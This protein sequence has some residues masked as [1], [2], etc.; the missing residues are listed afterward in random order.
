[1][2]N[3]GLEKR[4]FFVAESGCTTFYGRSQIMFIRQVFR[5]IISLI[6]LLSSCSSEQTDSE[7]TQ[8]G[9]S[10][11]VEVPDDLYQEG[12]IVETDEYKP[13]TKKLTVYGMILVG[14]ND[15]SDD[16]MKKVAKTIKEMFPQGGS[17]DAVLPAFSAVNPWC[18][19]RRR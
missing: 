19:S 16:F 15:V 14:G 11:T 2:G 17:I 7:T 8:W 1:M 13:F 9:I 3:L 4:L 6:L 18:L 5:A 12:D 10:P